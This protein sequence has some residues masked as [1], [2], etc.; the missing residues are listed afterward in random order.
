MTDKGATTHN[1][2]ICI[3]E[4]VVAISAEVDGAIPR[5]HS[6]ERETLRTFKTTTTR[7]RYR[8]AAEPKREEQKDEKQ[9]TPPPP[10]P[11]KDTTRPVQGLI[12]C[13]TSCA[14][15]VTLAG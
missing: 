15:L 12:D 13:A 8:S 4:L 1:I 2:Y 5:E 10:P 6:S 9:K 3:Y 14:L 11:K 7:A